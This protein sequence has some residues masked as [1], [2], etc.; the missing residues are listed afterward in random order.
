M[1]RPTPAKRDCPTPT[2]LHSA[3]S[4]LPKPTTPRGLEGAKQFSDAVGG[5]F[6]AF[7]DGLLFFE[8]LNSGDFTLKESNLT[9]FERATEKDDGC[10]RALGG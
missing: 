6:S 10:S 5:T 4:R 7:K 3:S 2:G 8:A 1:Y 9:T